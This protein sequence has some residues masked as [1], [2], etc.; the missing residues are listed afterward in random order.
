M[1]RQRQDNKGSPLTDQEK[2]DR[3]DYN[4]SI[5]CDDTSGGDCKY[6]KD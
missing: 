3:R 2:S 5:H 6:G 4:G 1:E